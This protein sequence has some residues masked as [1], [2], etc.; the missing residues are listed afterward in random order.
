MTCTDAL[1]PWAHGCAGAVTYLRVKLSDNNTE[2]GV[3]GLNTL[4]IMIL[5]QTVRMRSAESR[6][7]NIT[8]IGDVTPVLIMMRSTKYECKEKVQYD[9]RST[10]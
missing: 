1:M 8:I 6:I 5:L 7:I 9:P 2:V 4:T 10:S 3:K